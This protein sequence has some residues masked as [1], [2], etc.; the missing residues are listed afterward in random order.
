MGSNAKRLWVIRLFF[1]Y[2]LWG[3]FGISLLKRKM[4]R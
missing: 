1:T 2:I 4:K 3:N